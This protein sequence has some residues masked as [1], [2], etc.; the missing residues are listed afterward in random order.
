MC[1]ADDA[2]GGVRGTRVTPG[3]PGLHLL[4]RALTQGQ[5]GSYTVSPYPNPNTSKKSRSICDAV[6]HAFSRN[7]IP[8]RGCTAVTTDTCIPIA[9][10]PR[11]HYR[12]TAHPHCEKGHRVIPPSFRSFRGMSR[13]LPARKAAPARA[14]L[15]RSPTDVTV[16]GSFEARLAGRC[17]P[18][19]RSNQPSPVPSPFAA[20]ATTDFPRTCHLTYLLTARSACRRSLLIPIAVRMRSRK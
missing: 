1:A 8:G 15:C 20:T 2:V 6:Q 13:R 16:G 11:S 5:R 12:S 4:H 9:L 14:R 19:P 10:S 3:S 18:C 7:R 17:A